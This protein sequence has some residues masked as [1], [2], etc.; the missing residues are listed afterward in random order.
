V[1]PLRTGLASAD[2]QDD[3]M[4]AR[5]RAA[6]ARMARFLSRERGDIDVILPFDEV[7]DALG[8]VSQNDLGLRVIPL[9]S[10]VGTVDRSSG[11]DREFRPTTSRVRPR[12]ERIAAAMRRGQPMPPISVFRI[13]DAHFVRD[14]HHR[15][16]V[17]RALGLS[18]IEAFVTEVK[19]RVG[20]DRTL[21]LADLP[22]KS[23]ERLFFERV[24]LPRPA[25]ERLRLSDGERY[26]ALA[27]GVEAWGFRLMQDRAEFMD[28][29]HV[30]REWFEREFVPVVD[31]LR[32]AGMLGS[33]TEGDG[34][35]RVAEERY[36]LLRTHDW[37]EEVLARLR[38]AGG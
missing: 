2:A 20:A 17:A 38:E 9:E 5:R 14:G 36:R 18:D 12:W 11:F 6:A 27:E 29:P 7:V 26:A 23:S 22:V 8:R 37:S 28:R 35:M 10:I 33:G 24:P 30:A 15:V 25:R 32:E 21:R 31:M 4:R 16:S 34:Y 19:T 3:F 1:P 13:G